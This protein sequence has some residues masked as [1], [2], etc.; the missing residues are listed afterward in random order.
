MFKDKVLSK[1]VVVSKVI[2]DRERAYQII[3]N[4]QEF[5]DIALDEDESLDVRLDAIENIRDQ[6][7]LKNLADNSNADVRRIAVMHLTD[8]NVLEHLALDDED[9]DV[10]MEAAARIENQEFLYKLLF[11]EKNRHNTYI[12]YE[13]ADAIKD[14]KIIKRILDDYDK[15]LRPSATALQL[16]RQVHPLIEQRIRKKYIKNNPKLL[17]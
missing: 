14:K 9:V 1:Y 12:L 2:T 8:Q 3:A 5:E 17:N 10:R 7:V 15:S 11:T 4:E 13:I 16:S 6:K